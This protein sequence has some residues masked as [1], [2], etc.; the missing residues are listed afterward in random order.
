MNGTS[1]TE[2]GRCYAPLSD[3]QSSVFRYVLELPNAVRARYV[4][5]RFAESACSLIL[6]GELS[7][8]VYSDSEPERDPVYPPVVLPEP[9]GET[10]W[11][12][13]P[14]ELSLRRNLLAGLPVQIELP[15]GALCTA[16]SDNTPSGSLVLTDGK[17]APNI[18][19]HSGA[20]VKFR[21]DAARLLYFDLGK[22]VSVESLRLSFV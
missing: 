12:G 15:S 9:D 4:R 14:D 6:V 16:P 7:A 13:S 18:N 11:E 22:T 10:F 8:F 19:I 3:K 21:G 5:F 20:Y 2:A 1:W 17:A